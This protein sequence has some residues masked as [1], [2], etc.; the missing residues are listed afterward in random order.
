M[1]EHAARVWH[2]VRHLRSEQII[3]RLRRTL[4]RPSA[5]LRP[6]PARRANATRWT[7]RAARPTRMIG[8]D[9]FRFLGVERQ[10]RDTGD[11]NRGDWPKLWLYNLHYFDDLS[12]K[13][14]DA[15]VAWHADL[16]RRW[17]RENPPG[18]G[19]GWEPYC[20]S[21]RIVNWCKWAL[22]NGSLDPDLA[23]SLAVQARYLAQTVETH[24]LGNHL[25]ANLKALLFA[26]AFFDGPE[27]AHWQQLGSA[28]LARELPEQV[29]EDGAHFE[30]SPMY[31]AIVLEDLLDLIQLARI[32][33]GHFSDSNQAELREVAL[34]M[35][36]WLAVMTHP[37]G[38]IAFFNDAT[39]DVA[40]TPGALV[41]YAAQLELP[42]ARS[43]PGTQL[44]WA[45][46]Y[47][48][49]K[50]GSAVLLADVA[51][52]GPD[53]LPGH[54]HADTLS[55]ELSIGDRRLL[56]NSGVSEYC[57]GLERARQRGTAAHNTVMVGGL[58]SSEVWSS[59]RV[60]RRARP[61]GIRLTK[62]DGRPCLDA[63]HD[64]YVG[65]LGVVH[66]RR[67]ELAPNELVVTD[68]MEG[69]GR[70]AQAYWH[71][72][73]DTQVESASA[74]S[75]SLRLAGRAVCL[76]TQGGRLTVVPAT[77]HPEFGA[78]RANLCVRVDLE[79][80]C[81]MTRWSW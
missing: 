18:L 4:P 40:L 70:D 72:H 79:G 43:T 12:A 8:P 38:D 24:L 62:V 25:F 56:V 35:L 76:S 67:W 2:T 17:V 55:C 6:A 68:R 32:Y 49:I 64:G 52:V 11:W 75:L 77:W 60:A 71:L 41:D 73:P 29:L 53:H 33:P 57:E 39:L 74:S 65:R 47:A 45:S 20:L 22:A 42:A 81:A 15:R 44:C 13:D 28:Y 27:S 30:L 78:R 1:L 16:A 63:A 69:P 3:G 50:A 36:D 9:R 7:A 10:A 51:R 66:R 31:H 21:L 59:F 37:D 14:A 54:A 19:N 5:D 26:S 48:R 80:R 61:F 23:D 46:G 58:D 34:R